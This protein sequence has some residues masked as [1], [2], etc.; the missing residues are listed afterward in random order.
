VLG[1]GYYHFSRL[2]E[3]FILFE[4]SSKDK[5]SK[6]E[7]LLENQSIKKNHSVST[8]LIRKLERLTG[9][10]S[11]IGKKIFETG[12]TRIPSEISVPINKPN[13]S[14]PTSEISVPINKPSHSGP[15]SL[16]NLDPLD[17]ALLKTKM[18]F[19]VA[20]NLNLKSP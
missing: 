20:Q 19:G 18:P 5:I 17:T 4:W 2:E 16:V 3:M 13:Q 6:I 14:R 1:N 11:W 12:E 7:L 9:C 8:F 10:S 15:T